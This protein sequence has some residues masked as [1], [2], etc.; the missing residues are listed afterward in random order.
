MIKIK[1]NNFLLNDKNIIIGIGKQL[2]FL[3]TILSIF[4]AIFPFLL[5]P[6]FKIEILEGIILF[7]VYHLFLLVSFIL[8]WFITDI[9]II[10]NP[11]KKKIVKKVW[12][13][14]IYSYNF[15]LIK[16][17][18]LISSNQ[19]LDYYAFTLK[20]DP[21][22]KPIIISPRY[23][24]TKFDEYQLK[25]FEQLILPKIKTFIK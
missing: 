11:V 3:I 12:F 5:F 22:G 13:L 14:P 4:F 10:F 25:E 21:L 18:K 15:D 7:K 16:D 2:R 17:F 20:K 1:K 9:K 8:C 24:H 23:S 19:S 6:V